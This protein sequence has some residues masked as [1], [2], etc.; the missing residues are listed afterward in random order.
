MKKTVA[1]LLALVTVLSFPLSVLAA[2]ETHTVQYYSTTIR[3]FYYDNGYTDETVDMMVYPSEGEVYINAEDLGAL[4]G[5]LFNLSEDDCAYSSEARGHTVYYKFNAKKMLVYQSGYPL[6]YKMEYPA[7]YEDGVAWIPL[8]FGMKMLNMNYQV[9]ENGASCCLPYETV[10]SVAHRIMNG[11]FDF[12]Y[13]RDLGYSDLSMFGMETGAFLTGLFGGLIEMEGSCWGTLITSIFGNKDL[14][15][16]MLC[17]EVCSMFVM[18]G[19]N[20]VGELAHT[21][22]QIPLTTLKGESAVNDLYYDVM[23]VKIGKMAKNASKVSEEIKEVTKGVK[24]SDI[25]KNFSVGWEDGIGCLIDLAAMKLQ[26]ENREEVA[27]RALT[28]Y[29]KDCSLNVA[30][31]VK[32]Y[33]KDVNIDSDMQGAL[34]RYLKENWD[35]ILLGSINLGS[36]ALVNIGWSAVKVSFPYISD[37]LDSADSFSYSQQA[38]AMQS[39]AYWILED[40]YKDALSSKKVN[41]DSLERVANGCYTYLKFSYIARECAAASVNSS[42]EIDDAMKKSVVSRLQS[43]NKQIANMLSVVSCVEEGSAFGVDN[44]NGAYAS[45][46]PSEASGYDAAEFDAPAIDGL[47]KIGKLIS[48]SSQEIEPVDLVVI[49]EEEAIE[50]VRS[51]LNKYMMGLLDSKELQGMY[52]FECIERCDAYMIDLEDEGAFSDNPDFETEHCYIIQLYTGGNPDG[53]FCVATDGTGAYIGT[54]Y[55]ELEYAFMEDFN[56]ANLSLADLAGVIKQLYALVFKEMMNEAGVTTAPAT[57]TA[58]LN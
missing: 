53:L 22:Y 43:R 47:S 1:I 15:D 40:D 24:L 50:Q 29:G 44:E 4:S 57:D 49:T 18:P 35:N 41:E 20:E 55:G 23:S 52:T 37:S 17:E 11:E 3:L 16:G 34:S 39:D 6:S 31:T 54:E 51:S 56:L 45:M 14:Y 2:G 46:L 8:D 25:T 38:S 13:A 58:P 19:E 9:T 33:A 30:G 36:A 21:L 42:H 12:D 26:F 5:Y 10:F 48:S 28:Q 7:R 32:S 27:V